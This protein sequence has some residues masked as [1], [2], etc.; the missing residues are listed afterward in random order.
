MINREEHEQHDLD[1]KWELIDI[2]VI[3][4]LTSFAP[5]MIKYISGINHY[6][7]MIRMVNKSNTTSV[8]HCVIIM[9]GGIILHHA[10]IIRAIE[11]NERKN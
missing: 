3:N 7:N 1:E 4:V 11:R 5:S 2:D 8:C 6:G 9:K 10:K